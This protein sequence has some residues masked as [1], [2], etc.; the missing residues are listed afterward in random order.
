MLSIM[1]D[2]ILFSYIHIKRI[3]YLAQLPICMR[4]THI[5]YLQVKIQFLPLP[6]LDSWRWWLKLK[7]VWLEKHKTPAFKNAHCKLCLIIGNV[8]QNS[9]IWKHS[10]TLIHTSFRVLAMVIAKTWSS[11]L[12]YCVILCV[13]TS[14]FE[15]HGASVF[16]FEVCK[17]WV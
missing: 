13:S 12:W 17:A 15:Q 11:E 16:K 10:F 2:N 3:W 4:S 1:G 14:G 8:M 6:L 9:L 5:S 7:D